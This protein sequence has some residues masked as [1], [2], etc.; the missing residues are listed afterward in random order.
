MS[1]ILNEDPLSVSQITPNVPQG[2][3]RVVTRCLAKNP[4]QR[5]QNASDLE[6]ALEALSDSSGSSIAVA[7][8][9]SRARWLWG[10][11]VGVL[12]LA[13]A[14]FAWWKMP[15]SVPVIESVT[16]LTDDGEAK[17]GAIQS[18]AS[19]V[20]FNEGLTGAGRSHRSPSV[21][22]RPPRSLL[23]C[24]IRR[25]RAWHSMV[26]NYS[27]FR[28]GLMFQRVPCGRFHFL[29]ESPAVSAISMGSLPISSPMAASSF[30]PPRSCTSPTKTAQTCASCT[31]APVVRGIQPCHLTSTRVAF[32]TMTDGK[33]T[34]AEIA[35]DGTN[36]RILLKGACCARWSSDGNYLVYRIRHAGASDIWALSMQTG[37]FHRSRLPI[38]LTNGP[39]AY[40]AVAPSRDGRQIFAIGTKRRGELV[41]YDMKSN[42]FVPFLSGI[43]AIDPTFSDDGQWVTYISYPDHTLWR[44]RSD[45]SE[46]MQLTYPPM[47][48]AYPSISP[49]GT[50]VV[51]SSFDSETFIVGMDGGQPQRIVEKNFRQRELVPRRKTRGCYFV[52]RWCRQRTTQLFSSDI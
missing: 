30:L 18:D 43:S 32:T 50:R 8:Q 9:S 40:N 3:Q 21:A 44:S 10:A 49:D 36:F 16:Q 26:P 7:R 52:G 19:R 24:R 22:D 31:P 12:I 46:R 4:A 17:Q 37:I 35:P 13:A 47:E 29:R 41:R 48:A 34:L 11:A 5:I 20:Y 42:Q 45:G 6:F 33:L 38:R 15:P 27:H 28:A 51:F 1:A 23:S 2:L 14:L 25:L 39:L